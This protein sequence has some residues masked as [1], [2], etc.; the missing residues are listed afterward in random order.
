M[1]TTSKRETADLSVCVDCV[2]YL[3]N[4]E[5]SDPDTGENIATAHAAKIAAIW[6]DAFDITLGSLPCEHCGSKARETGDDVQDCEP[7]FSWH[8]CDG[9]GS[10]L[11]GDREHATA[12]IDPDNDTRQH[13]DDSDLSAYA[14]DAFGRDYS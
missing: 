6:G 2:S 8:D 11:G 10:T 4:G 3:A 7:W 5:V 14:G 9:C 13:G 1:T 12:W